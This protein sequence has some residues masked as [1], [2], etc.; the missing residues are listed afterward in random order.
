[1]ES[2]IQTTA[3]CST[4]ERIRDEIDGWPKI[5]L[6]RDGKLYYGDLHLFTI[7]IN[8]NKLKIVFIVN[9]DKPEVLNFFQKKVKFNCPY[10]REIKESKK[11]IDAPYKFRPP[12]SQNYSSKMIDSGISNGT[13]CL[14]EGVLYMIGT[15]KK[16]VEHTINEISYTI[17][18]KLYDNDTNFRTSS[19]ISNVRNICSFISR[20]MWNGMDKYYIHRVP[21]LMLKD[22]TQNDEKYSGHYPHITKHL[23]DSIMCQEI[24]SYIGCD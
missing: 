9:N 12:M 18:F 8:N 19:I 3:F 2:Q 7:M 15:I 23:F 1:M 10:Q 24:C 22:G 17:N 11:Y 16:M 14:E 13:L 5:I 20:D 21:Y 4:I 6:Q